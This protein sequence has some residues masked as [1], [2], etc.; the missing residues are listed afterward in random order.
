MSAPDIFQIPRKVWTRKEV[1]RFA[2]N[3]LS[4]ELVNGELID[5]MG[6]KPP[7]IYWKGV[8]GD[9]LRQQFGFEY[10]RSEDLIDV[11]PEDNPTSEPEPDLS[12]PFRSRHDLRFTTV[13]PE[14][15]RLVVEISDTIY[16]YDRTVKATLYARAGIREYWIVDIRNPD[17]PK[18]IVHLDPQNNAYQLSVFGP[19]EQATV[20]RD[21]TLRLGDLR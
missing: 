10:V 2:W 6:K 20:L 11:A 4:L 3:G 21:R 8:L 15:L 12:V 17:A 16:D 19:K 13:K 9:W 18:L 5:K 14:D 7:H 1:D